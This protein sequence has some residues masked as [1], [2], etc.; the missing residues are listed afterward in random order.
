MI[1]LVKGKAAHSPNKVIYMNEDKQCNLYKIIMMTVLVGVFALIIFTAIVIDLTNREYN[2]M[3]KSCPS[4]SFIEEVFMTRN[5][6]V[7]GA[8]INQDTIYYTISANGFDYKV[9]YKLSRK[10]FIYWQ[11]KYIRHIEIATTYNERTN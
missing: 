8:E 10:K 9:E 7:N 11:W 3:L 6:V 1:D 5:V 4:I 2:R